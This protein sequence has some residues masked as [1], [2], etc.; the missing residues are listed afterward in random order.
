MFCVQCLPRTEPVRPRSLQGVRGFRTRRPPQDRP[1]S[2]AEGGKPHL[3]RL[4]FLSAPLQ[5][6]VTAMTKA[7]ALDESQYGVRVNW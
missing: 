4:S 1:W 2:G 6:A 5:G 3:P 7:L